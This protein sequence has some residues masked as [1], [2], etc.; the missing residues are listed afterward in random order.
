MGIFAQDLKESV[1]L[2]TLTQLNQWTP[3]IEVLLLGTASIMSNLGDRLLTDGLAANNQ[4]RLFGLYLI[5]KKK[6]R[7]IW[8][9]HIALDSEMASI[10]RGFASQR[11]F[12]E[13][14]ENELVT[15]LSYATAIAWATYD[16]NLTE[17]PDDPC[18]LLELATCW[19]DHHPHNLPDAHKENAITQFIT[20]LRTI[21]L[22]PGNKPQLV[23]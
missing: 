9:N 20:G 2:P 17:F 1:I 22:S 5:D 14:P 10:I 4:N 23:A 18:N 16:R 19:F 12:L 11:L 7:D 8:D 6:H 15:N 13:N 3:A 21:I